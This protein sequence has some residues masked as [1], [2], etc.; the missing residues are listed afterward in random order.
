MRPQRARGARSPEPGHRLGLSTA[1]IGA[2][3]DALASAFD[4]RFLD[5]D[6]VG[7]VRR[8][9]RPEDREIAGL[10]AA[11]LAYGR[12]AGIRSSVG[13]IL[14][15]LGRSPSRRVDEAE[16]GAMTKRLEGVGHRF[17]RGSDVGALLDLVAEARRRAGSLESF[18]L[19]GDEPAAD[20]TLGAAMASFASRLF[21]LGSGAR[22]T[23]EGTRWLFPSPA[24]GSACKR[25]CL[26]LRWMARPD[27]GVDCG[28]WGRVDPSRLVVPLDTHVARVGAALGWTRRRAPSWRMALEITECLRA[29]DPADPTRYD[30]ALSRL[31]ILGVVRARGGR[32]RLR[33]VATAL[34]CGGA[35]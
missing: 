18:F 16:P 11:G 33:D 13:R 29:L 12:V 19:A 21:S 26:F 27:D 22:A 25:S 14:D 32:I 23:P 1:E 3:L 34:R 9:D 20:P 31:G 30:F 10:V 5:S 28:V 24:G 4:R 7:L 2:R 17:T 8:Y 15:R 6:P 35:A